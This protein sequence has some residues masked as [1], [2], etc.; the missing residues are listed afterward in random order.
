MTIFNKLSLRSRL[1]LLVLIVA[2]PA[3]GTNIFSYFE[4]V[5][6]RMEE[7]RGDGLRIL[8]GILQRQ[9]MIAS[10]TRQFLS[11]LAETPSVRNRDAAACEALFRELLALNP[12]YSIIM[13]LTPQGVGFAS[14]APF[15]SRDFSD[16]KYYRDVLKTGKF[17]VGEYTI[18]RL[19]HVPVLQF[20]HPVK[21]SRGRLAAI[22]V[23]ALKLDPSMQPLS[24]NASCPGAMSS[25]SRTT[26][27]NVSSAI[28]RWRNSSPETP[29]SMDI[30]NKMQQAGDEGGFEGTGGGRCQAALRL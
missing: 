2:L 25:P 9:E 16:R 18:G 23:V 8:D 26:R 12:H 10:N 28:R 14:T 22:L 5:R 4:E 1:F 3:A 24:A 13:A 21:D 30:W 6:Y 20:A 19:T 11:T 15:E 17:S 7:T 29:V 27:G